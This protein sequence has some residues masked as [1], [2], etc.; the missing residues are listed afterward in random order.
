MTSPATLAAGLRALLRLRHPLHHH[1]H[2]RMTR[3]DVRDSA[4]PVVLSA[5]RWLASVNACHPWDHNEHFHGWIL[6]NLPAGGRLSTSAAGRARW[7]EG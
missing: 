2:R 7:P 6:R 5:G 3:L 4:N 1:R